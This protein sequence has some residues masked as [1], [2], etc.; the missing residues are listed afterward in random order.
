MARNVTTTTSGGASADQLG[1][2]RVSLRG[3][4]AESR[5]QACSSSE[6]GTL[7]TCSASSRKTSRRCIEVGADDGEAAQRE[8][9]EVVGHELQELAARARPDAGCISVLGLH[10]CRRARGDVLELLVREQPRD[11]DVARLLGREVV[12]LVADEMLFLRQQSGRLDLEQRGGERARKSLATSRSRS[13]IRS[14]CSRYWSAMSRHRDGADVELLRRHE[15][16][17]QVE[18]PLED[19][20]LDRVSPRAAPGGLRTRRRTYR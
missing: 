11:E 8:T 10:A 20:S 1:E 12:E 9:F 14:M 3:S 17:Q 13:F 18:R 5:S 6:I 16:Q 19:V 4:N 7:A 2:A 15:V